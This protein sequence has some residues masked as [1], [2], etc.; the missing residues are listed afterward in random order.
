MG[1][2]CKGPKQALHSIN[3]LIDSKK[4]LKNMHPLFSTQKRNIKK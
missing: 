3:T 4:V 1:T 2:V